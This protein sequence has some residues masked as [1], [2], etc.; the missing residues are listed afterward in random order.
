MLR[1]TA[2]EVKALNDF[3]LIIKFDNDEIKLFDANILFSRKPFLPLMD[4]SVFKT[5]KPN[6]I[7]LE[8]DNDID[9]CP[10]ELYYNS[11]AFIQEN[12]IN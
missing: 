3:K 4:K 5:V 12:N 6:G 2:I 1:P 7:T 11:V 9:I 10:D 8:W